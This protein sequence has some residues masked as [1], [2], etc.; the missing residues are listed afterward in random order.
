MTG[1]PATDEQLAEHLGI[2]MDELLDWQS[3]LKTTNVVSLNEF[4]EQGV[5][6]AM[7]ARKNSHFEQPEES[8]S[9]KELKAVLAKALSDLTENEK[10]VILLYN[11][12]I[13]LF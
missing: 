5:E 3:I 11:I 7:D 6:P 10:K 4:V 2:S 12:I 13:C 8:V 9:K 1:K